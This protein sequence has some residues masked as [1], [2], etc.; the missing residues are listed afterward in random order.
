MTSSGYRKVP[1]NKCEGGDDKKA[2]PVSR[3]CASSPSTPS[4]PSG[5]PS[6]NSN[7]F[8]S[9]LMNGHFVK[10]NSKVV[11]LD[12]NGA[13]FRS[14]DE[15]KT[16]ASVNFPEPIITIQTHDSVSA[17]MFFFS[18]T[19]VYA[20]TNG[21][22]DFSLMALPETYNNFNIPVFD[23]HPLETDWYV[24]IAA[25]RNCP[26]C[27]TKVYITKDAGKTFTQIDEWT[28]NVTM[29][30]P[31]AFGLLIRNLMILH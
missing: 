12:S 28:E 11:L 22:N 6:L 4:V 20:T 1:G 29:S 3:P 9:Q 5:Q 24:F 16:W 30:K 14:T 8:K 19:Q 2:D 21:L 15:G 18:A 13:V 27:F 10:D 23:F 26:G 25:S 17:R 31:S 7:T